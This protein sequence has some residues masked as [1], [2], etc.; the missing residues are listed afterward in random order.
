MIHIT[1]THSYVWMD[2]WMDGWGIFMHEYSCVCMWVEIC[3]HIC[4][5]YTCM[6]S[7]MNVRI[8]VTYMCMLACTCVCM[9]ACKHAFVCMFLCMHNFNINT[10]I[11]H[12]YNCKSVFIYPKSDIHIR[13]WLLALKRIKCYKNFHQ[14]KASGAILN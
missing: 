13:N 10:Y 12:A 7:F 1:S 11:T 9:H 8:Y 4:V 6:Y 3:M 2:W 5:I 14:K